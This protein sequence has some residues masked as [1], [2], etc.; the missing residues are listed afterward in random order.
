ML[1]S[2]TGGLQPKAIAPNNAP[3]NKYV[4]HNLKLCSNHSPFIKKTR[5]HI[6]KQTADIIAVQYKAGAA[7]L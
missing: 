3:V 7:I 6:I 1:A 4:L 2:A 5:H